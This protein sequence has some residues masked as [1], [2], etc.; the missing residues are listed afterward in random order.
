MP[1]ISGGKQWG[2]LLNASN[3]LLILVVVACTI[4][5][6]PKSKQYS[7]AD[8]VA[9]KARAIEKMV[10]YTAESWI[11]PHDGTHQRN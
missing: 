7:N 10:T 8:V 6:S 4:R 2:Q 11:Q 1:V 9:V 5:I 3:V